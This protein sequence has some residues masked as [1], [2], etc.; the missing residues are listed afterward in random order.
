MVS[1]ARDD[2][3][4]P[5]SPVK[6]MSLS[7]GSSMPTF[8]RLC[9]RA[10]RTTRVSD[11][12]ARLAVRANRRTLV[13]RELVDSEVERTPVEGR[14]LLADEVGGAELLTGPGALVDDQERGQ[15]L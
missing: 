3:P 14:P 5:D 10:P 12:R 7:R 11:T 9:S 15:P 4:E 8:F 13:R 1:K 2:L 6:T